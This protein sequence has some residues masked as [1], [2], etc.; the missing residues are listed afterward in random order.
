MTP[1]ERAARALAK[2]ESGEDCYDSFDE[3]FQKTF[4]DGARAV[5]EAVMA[6]IDAYDPYLHQTGKP[7]VLRVTGPIAYTLA[8]RRIMADHPHRDVDG[9]NEIGLEY[10]VYGNDMQ[11]VTVFT[12]HY[13]KQTASIVRL[14]P[15]KRLVSR[16]YGIAQRLHDRVRHPAK[17]KD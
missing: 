2:A 14:S 4:K 6:N 10:N 17:L 7:G 5:L 9:R 16:V 12:G 1:L 3:D 8:I 13:S 11:H 15:L